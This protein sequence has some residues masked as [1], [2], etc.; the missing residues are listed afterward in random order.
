MRKRVGWI[1][2][3]V[4]IEGARNV[5]C[6]LFRHVLIIF[7]MALSD[8]RARQA[9]LCAERPQ[10]LDLLTRH[11]IRD[12]EDDAVTLRDAD[13][14][15]AQA[16]IAGCRFDDGAARRKLLVALGVGDHGERDAVLDRAA[17]V[18]AF[19][20]QEK[21]ALAGVEFGQ[22]DHR[23]FADQLQDRG[24]GR[25]QSAGLDFRMLAHPGYSLIDGKRGARFAHPI[26]R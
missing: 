21:A 10:V 17:G 3:L 16:R 1:G 9:N 12:N 4:D 20:F 8:I 14:G 22:F 25:A 13:L 18:L 23:S 7:G 26:T 15:K 11:L 6:D 24:M 19:E 2:E 5:G